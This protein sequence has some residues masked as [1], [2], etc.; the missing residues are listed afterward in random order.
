M[1]TTPHSTPPAT[2]HAHLALS[3]V[4]SVRFVTRMRWKP[5]PVWMGP[6]TSHSGAL[7]HSRLLSLMEEEQLVERALRP[8]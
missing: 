4:G 2:R 7:Q 8:V 3:A 5:N 1:H 6:C